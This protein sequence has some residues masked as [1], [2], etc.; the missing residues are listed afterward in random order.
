[1]NEPDRD[2]EGLLAA[3]GAGDHQAFAVLVILLL[4]R[5]GAKPVPPG[6]GHEVGE[7]VPMNAE[8]TVSFD[9]EDLMLAQQ[10]EFAIGLSPQAPGQVVM[11][12][13]HREPA[14]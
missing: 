8:D 2:S 1:M 13:T 14:A 4:R 5:L 3:L 10:F 9:R 7:Y 6:M 12:L 11:I